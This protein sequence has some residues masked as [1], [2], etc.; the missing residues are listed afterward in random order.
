MT[1]YPVAPAPGSADREG[2]SAPTVVGREGYV[3]RRLVGIA[4]IGSA[5]A[6]AILLGVAMAGLLG[7]GSAASVPTA[8]PRQVAA[9]SGRP[10]PPSAP[11]PSPSVASNPMPS[12]TPTP[13]ATPTATPLPTP[14]TVPTPT[15]L[16]TPSPTP[17]PTTAP[18]T[19]EIV[20]FIVAERRPIAVM[21]DDLA[22][23]RPQSG[24]SSADIVWHAPAE[25]GI[26]RYMAVFQTDLDTDIGPVRSARSYYV[27][28]ATE[29]RASR[30]EYIRAFLS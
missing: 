22:P 28:W 5:L 16:P 7:P 1:R 3:G 6:V 30:D 23:A 9:A 19:G 12:P 13:R 21:I 15:P 26:P 4:V 18:L 17:G 24:L 20:P 10:V 27:A 2:R 25:G 11:A 29:L 8:T 14:P